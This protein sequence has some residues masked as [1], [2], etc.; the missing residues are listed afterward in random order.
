MEAWW[1]GLTTLNKAFAISALAFSAAFLVQLV[2]M[3]LGIDSDTST[4]ISGGTGVHDIHDVHGPDA[5]HSAAGVAFSFVSIRSLMAFGT[6]FSWAGTL[7][8]A[9]GTYANL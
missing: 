2:I 3:L 1:E 6:L 9:V 5:D 4:R 7:Y 8:L